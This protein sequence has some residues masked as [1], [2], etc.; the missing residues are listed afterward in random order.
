[1]RRLLLL[2]HAKSCWDEPELADVDRPLASRG[3]AAAPAIGRYMGAE[4]W[5]PDLALCSPAVRVRETWQLVAP[6]LGAPIPTKTLRSLYLAS[7]SRLLA[8]VRRIAPKVRTLMMI[9]HNPGFGRFAVDLCGEGPRK[10][11]ER[12]GSKFPTAALAVIDFDV[13]QWSEVAVAGGRLV[14]FVRPKDLA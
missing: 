1:M 8:T 3:R 11:L 12:M 14:A 13:D 6:A 4:G 2:R 5:Q 10:A 7:P 9:G